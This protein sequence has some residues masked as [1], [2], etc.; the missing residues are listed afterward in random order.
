[1]DASVPGLSGQVAGLLAGTIDL[2]QFQAWFIVTETAI[3]QRAMSRDA[4]LR[5]A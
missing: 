3:E 1:M 4:S 5:S 2:E